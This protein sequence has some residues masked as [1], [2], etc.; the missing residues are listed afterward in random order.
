MKFFGLLFFTALIG[1]GCSSDKR[2]PKRFDHGQTQAEISKLQKVWTVTCEDAN[3]CPGYVGQLEIRVT[4]QEKPLVCNGF[5][6]DSQTIA[7]ASH[8]IPEPNLCSKNVS[9]HFPMTAKNSAEVGECEKVIVQSDPSKTI[10]E[11]DFALFKLKTATKRP[12]IPLNLINGVEDQEQVFAVKIDA[13]SNANV[14]GILRVVECH[15]AYGKGLA[16]NSKKPFSGAHALTGCDMLPGNSGAPLLG[17][18]LRSAK[19]I[20]LGKNK[21]YLKE[22]KIVYA[23]NASCVDVDKAPKN[24]N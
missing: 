2:A 17:Q 16:E 21:D 12:S 7:T 22:P 15:V 13:V 18:D 14:K 24:C 19:L 4:G 9:I 1:V 10:P 5:L 3:K 6:I 11:P 8:C 20:L 23:T